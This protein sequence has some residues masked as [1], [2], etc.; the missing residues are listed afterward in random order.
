MIWAWF[1]IVYAV[2]GVLIAT[3]FSRWTPEGGAPLT[4]GER[5][6]VIFVVATAWPL[7]LSGRITILFLRLLGRLGTPR[8]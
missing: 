5:G 8:Q 6:L 4:D 2:V 7:F 1:A 3:S